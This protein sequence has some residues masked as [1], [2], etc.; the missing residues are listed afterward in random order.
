MGT[1]EQFAFLVRLALL[2]RLSLERPEF[3][4]FDDPLTNTDPVRMAA[5]REMLSEVGRRAQILIFTCNP[6]FYEGLKGANWVD[7]E[8]A[9]EGA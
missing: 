9:R 1:K 7:L 5:I 4:V 2:E 3:A 8:R 6:Q